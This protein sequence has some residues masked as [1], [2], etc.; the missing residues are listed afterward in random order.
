M[1]P[2][3]LMACSQTGNELEIN[4]NLEDIP[5]A[6]RILSMEEA[7]ELAG[8]FMSS[9]HDDDQ[10]T[11]GI[12]TFGATSVEVLNLR[13]LTRSESADTVFYVVNF[14]DGGYSLVA[15]DRELENNIY[16][17]SETDTF[18]IKDNPVMRLYIENAI[19][20]LSD[21]PR[22]HKNDEM[23]INTTR[24]PQVPNPDEPIHG[25]DEEINGV[26]CKAVY[27]NSHSLKEPL[28]S[29]LWHQRA[30]YNIFCPL[31]DEANTL[32][33]CGAIA[34]GQICAFNRKPGNLDGSILNWDSMLSYNRHENQYY[35]GL[36]EVADFLHK[37]G[38][39]INMNY[40]IN[41]S[42]SSLN[43]ALTGFKRLG[44]NSAIKTTFSSAE[45]VRSLKG[46]H[47]VFM[48]GANPNKEGHFWVVDGYDN[49]SSWV[50]YYRIDNG[51]LYGSYGIGTYTY[52]H[53]N[54]GWEDT[55]WNTYYLC[56][57]KDPNK[58]YK[59]FT[60]FTYTEYNQIITNIE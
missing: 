36:Y 49:M 34:V 17:Y 23:A 39:I 41:S 27:K 18:E 48:F 32:V 11:R 58:K 37:I 29:T 30:P 33:G 35:P 3:I 2:W 42:S 15:A 47:P 26:K 28:L 55:N 43:D 10:F 25:G 13:D 19:T 57:G 45:C 38:V 7:A 14:E 51:E 40:G 56:G 9:L 21:A 4:S 6:S 52:L 5:T 12:D 50:E 53:F 44:Y 46:N 1:M 22:R 59:D 24:A 31:Q 60:V 54:A 16:M 20:S 8:N